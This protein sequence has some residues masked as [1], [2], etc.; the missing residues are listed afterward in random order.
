M[1]TTLLLAGLIALSSA[2]LPLS[3]QPATAPAPVRLKGMLQ[4][5]TVEKAA[6]L[7]V[8]A[9]SGSQ[10]AVLDQSAPNLN[11]KLSQIQDHNNGWLELATGQIEGTSLKLSGKYFVPA[12]ATT[13]RPDGLR[14]TVR[15][16]TKTGLDI[17]S[18]ITV[19]IPA[20]SVGMWVRFDTVLPMKAE[21][22]PVPGN[23]VLMLS[24]TPLAGPVY[25][26]DLSVTDASG[27][28]LW[29][30]PSFE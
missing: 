13:Y 21:A 23:Y 7:K 25:L 20:K 18:E 2:A 9:P 4:Q 17:Y 11:E 19:K 24:A 12:A 29:A 28:A 27:K 10:V 5:I 30:Y 3:A 16:R 14:L 1:K 15:K 26:D 22:E 8:T 6:A